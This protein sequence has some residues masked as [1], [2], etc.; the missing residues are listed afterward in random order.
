MKNLLAL[1]AVSIM[2]SGATAFAGCPCQAP[3]VIQSAPY[4]VTYVQP[5]QQVLPC[6]KPCCNKAVKKGFFGNM[7]SSTRSMYDRTFGSFFNTV[8]GQ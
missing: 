6:A 1:A 8:T 5:V 4:R 7:W 2:L 3:H